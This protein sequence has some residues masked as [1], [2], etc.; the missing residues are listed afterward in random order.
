MGSL[1]WDSINKKESR[2]LL[3]VVETRV[4]HAGG[5]TNRG[6]GAFLHDCEIES[7][8]IFKRTFSRDDCFGVITER[9][10]PGPRALITKGQRTTRRRRQEGSE[11]RRWT[12]ASAL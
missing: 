11:R 8:S 3:S 10:D 7:V 9:G 4:F 1:S 12:H 5:E 6:V 2:R